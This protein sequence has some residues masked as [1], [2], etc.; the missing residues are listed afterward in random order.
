MKHIIQEILLVS[1]IT[2][3]CVSAALFIAQTGNS[4]SY[5]GL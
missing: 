4:I 3:I 2:V 5:R 1:I